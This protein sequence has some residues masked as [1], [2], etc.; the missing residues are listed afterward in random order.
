MNA[1]LTLF[2]IA[3]CVTLVIACII[4]VHKLKN[5]KL[6]IFRL[7]NE[8]LYLTKQNDLYEKQ[9]GAVNNF[10]EILTNSIPGIFCVTDESGKVIKHNRNYE[11]IAK[12]V[13]DNIV[14]HNIFQ[15][16]SEKSPDFKKQKIKEVFQTKCHFNV[17]LLAG[18][19]SDKKITYFFTGSP[20]VVEDRK[21]LVGIGFDISLYKQAQEER[22]QSEERLRLAAEATEL[23]TWDWDL[24]TGI[25]RWSDRGYTIFGLEP[26]TPVNFDSSLSCVHPDDQKGAHAAVLAALDPVNTQDFDTEFRVIWPDNSVHWVSACGKAYFEE[27]DGKLRATRM[28]GIT[29][30]ITQRKFIT[31]ALRES[32]QK[33]RSLFAVEPDALIL[34]DR[35]TLR[36]ME[37]NQSALELYGYGRIEFLSLDI[38]AILACEDETEDL[39]QKFGSDT[40]YGVEC[41]H[42]NRDGKIIP[43]EVSGCVFE[44]NEREVIYFF[45]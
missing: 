44:L 26:G 31:E 29:L 17:E 14:N 28:N 1:C 6:E 13:A 38:L 2:A 43:V 10:A 41:L 35:Q 34:F 23:G 20:F 5:R 22:S 7:E 21:Y 3:I 9:L 30:D 45:N 15:I 25:Y 39:F 37:A 32:E 8:L 24:V 11:E 19:S 12:S 27:I 33:Y 36:I 4:L 18:E 40:R 16:L 42:K